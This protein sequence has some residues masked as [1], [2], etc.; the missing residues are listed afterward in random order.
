MQYGSPA[1]AGLLLF[2]AGRAIHATRPH[3]TASGGVEKIHPPIEADAT[4]ISPRGHGRA[5]LRLTPRSPFTG[6]PHYTPRTASG[7]SGQPNAALRLRRSRNRPA[8]GS[9]PA[10]RPDDAHRPSGLCSNVVGRAT[11]AST[12]AA[13]S[14]GMSEL[15]TTTLAARPTAMPAGG[16]IGADRPTTGKSTDAPATHWSAGV[17]RSSMDDSARRIGRQAHLR[18][19]GVV[20]ALRAAHRRRARRRADLRSVQPAR[21]AAG[22]TRTCSSC[23]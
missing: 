22:A 7:R 16:A 11:P 6:S 1:S 19:P 20:S 9:D 3:D 10:V 17:L 18:G 14:R 23:S 5:A 2:G 4:S 12:A 8:A 21:A 15:S 13:T